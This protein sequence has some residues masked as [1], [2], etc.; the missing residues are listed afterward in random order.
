MNE[1]IDETQKRAT[2]AEGEPN[3]LPPGTRAATVM[4]TQDPPPA[5]RMPGAGDIGIQGSPPVLLFD[6]AQN[7]LDLAKQLSG[8]AKQTDK[9]MA[10]IFAQS[11]CELHTE[12]ALNSLLHRLSPE[13]REAVL[14]LC[15]QGAISFIDVGTRRLWRALTNDHPPEQK[16]WKAW[17]GNRDL[18]NAIAH[19]GR[20][21]TTGEV[22]ESIG[23]AVL[24]MGHVTTVEKAALSRSPRP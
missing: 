18:R 10:V 8:S 19:E 11:A 15:G 3:E 14:A 24:Y 23:L 21:V 2:P 12:R 7:L 5:Q 1:P 9:Q 22:A 20:Q 4:A 16:W 17:I 13:V 6:A